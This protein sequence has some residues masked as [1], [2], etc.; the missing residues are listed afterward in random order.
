M[1]R[2]TKKI[3]EQAD[4]L[5]RRFEEYEPDPEDLHPG[6]SLA[7]VYRAALARI[8]GEAA[9]TEAITAARKDSHSWASIGGLIGTT[10]E[11]ARQ[12]YGNRRKAS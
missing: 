9:L 2:S 1:P 5:A 7:A 12:R 10:G 4:E 3:L 6:E 8:E 11:A